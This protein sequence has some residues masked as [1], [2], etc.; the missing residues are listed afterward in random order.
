MFTI[1][2]MIEKCQENIWLKYGALSDDP[3]AEFDY[4]F[5]LKNCKTIIEFVEFMKQGNWAIRQGVS[6]GNLLF[7]NQING[8]DE[9]LSIKKDEEGNL[10]AFDSISFLSI[11]ESLGDEKFIDFIQELLKKSKHDKCNEKKL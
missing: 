2:E 1:E 9:W 7:V 8:G 10:K 11:Y 4:E 5:T 6:I 3:C